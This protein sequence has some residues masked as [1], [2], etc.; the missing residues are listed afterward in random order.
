ML[1]VL[2]AI[3]GLMGALFAVALLLQDVGGPGLTAALC[4]FAL[5]L[6]ASAAVLSPTRRWSWWLASVAP[7]ALASA[8]M[9]AFF[10]AFDDSWRA[11][12]YYRHWGAM[13]QT[14]AVPVVFTVGPMLLLWTLWRTRARARS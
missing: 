8:G 14:L 6:F 4:A 12:W 9:W 5:T 10:S 13:A 1:G 3:F 2:R 11:D 7:C